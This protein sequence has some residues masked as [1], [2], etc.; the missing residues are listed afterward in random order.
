[1]A[2]D[3]ELFRQLASLR[4]EEA[5][6]LA[7]AG[8]ASGAYYLAGYIVECA[9]KARIA[10]QFKA[11]EIPDKKLVNSLYTHDLEALL[12]LAGL[13]Q[14]LSTAIDAD[15]SLKRR[16]LI[17]QRWSENARYQIWT[18]DDAADMIDAVDGNGTQQGLF[19]WLS[20]R[21]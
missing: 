16:W 9:L 1:M 10:G 13:D 5:K 21:W 20:A 12:R 11:N 15:L 17:I 2:H 4:L 7:Q 18:R 6:A 14:E 19:R 3:R 8:N